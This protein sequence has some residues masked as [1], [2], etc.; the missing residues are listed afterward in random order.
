MSCPL[1]VP[2]AFHYLATRAGF[3]TGSCLNVGQS[4]L[5]ED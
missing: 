1:G 2:G 4:L 3:W 5:V